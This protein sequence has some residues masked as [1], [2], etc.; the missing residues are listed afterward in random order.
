V[1][2][3]APG[4]IATPINEEVLDDPKDR[5]KIESEIPLGRWGEVSDVARAVAWSRPI[6]RSTSSASRSSSTA[7]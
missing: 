1:V 4:A 5:R 7:G 2:S 6:R 3:I